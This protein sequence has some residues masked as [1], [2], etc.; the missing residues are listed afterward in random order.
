MSVA[1]GT[2]FEN[3][4]LN[5]LATFKFKLFRVGGANDKG[6]CS[7]HFSDNRLIYADIGIS[8]MIIK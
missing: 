4:T 3:Q 2:N 7:K 8:P 6:V 1:I 5:F